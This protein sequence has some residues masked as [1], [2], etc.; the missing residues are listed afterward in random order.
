[1][2]ISQWIVKVALKVTSNSAKFIKYG[3]VEFGF[4]THHLEICV[5]G[6][7]PTIA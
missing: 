4:L 7:D 1:M 5:L 3:V 2:S 6:S